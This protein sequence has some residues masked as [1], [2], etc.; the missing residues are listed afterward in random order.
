MPENVNQCIALEW[1]IGWGPVSNILHPMSL[2]KLDGVVA[3]ACQ[4]FSQFTRSSVIDAEFV[5]AA[6]SLI[7]VRVILRPSGAKRSRENGCGWKQLEQ[8]S[9][10][11]GGHSNTAK[12]D[13]A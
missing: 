4:Q 8:G 12:S 1:L 10:F 11:H 13:L 7:R 9:S 5:D 6:R 3:E 2:K